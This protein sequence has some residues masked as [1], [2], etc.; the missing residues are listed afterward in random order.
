MLEGNA[1]MYEGGCHCGAVRYAIEGAPRHVSV[2]HCTDCRRCAGATG[3]A[4][5]GFPI[6]ALSF[7]GEPAVYMSSPGVERR[8][9]LI[10]GTGLFYVTAEAPAQ[11]DV[12]VATLDDPD[13]LPPTKHVQ[14][15][16][17]VAW[18]AKLHTLPAHP[19]FPGG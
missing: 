2:C 4:W 8:F 14:M 9:C 16:E 7:S 13:E 15:A 3:V 18:E 11:V 10:C 19:R 6:E 12:Q 1:A 17:A 5:A